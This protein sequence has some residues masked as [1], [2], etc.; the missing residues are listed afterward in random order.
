[1]ADQVEHSQ[2]IRQCPSLGL[3]NPHQGRVKDKLPVHG[4]VERYVQRFD[5]GIPA[6]GIP[7]EIRLRHTRHDVIDALFAG[8]DGGNAKKEQVASRHKSVRET[9]RRF[10]LIHSHTGVRQG[11]ASQLTDERNIHHFKLHSRFTRYLPRQVHF[12]PVLLPIQETQ[13]IYFLKLTL[14]PE[15]ASCRILPTAEHDQ[16][17]FFVHP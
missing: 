5:E 6:I 3:V 7:A 16:C 9:I 13:R 8:I 10:F 4:K 15:Q 11:V 17:C 14:C 1:M 2:L 12:L